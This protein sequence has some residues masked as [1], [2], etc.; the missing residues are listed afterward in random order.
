MTNKD[1]YIPYNWL[2]P[3]AE[4]DRREEKISSAK[5]KFLYVTVHAIPQGERRD[6]A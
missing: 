4:E 1:E 5:P 6:L 2:A 3:L